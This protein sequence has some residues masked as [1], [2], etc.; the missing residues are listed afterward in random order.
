M[1]KDWLQRMPKVELHLH[2]EGSVTPVDLSELARR[3]RLPD[4]DWPVEAVEAKYRYDDF[5]GFLQAFKWITEHLIRPGDYGWIASRQIER[6]HTA[7]VI[8]AE[9]FFS[10]GV[11]LK[12]GKDLEAILRAV[13]TASRKQEQRWG[14]RVNWIFDVTRQ[15]GV[16]LA[17]QVLDA[18][19]RL[20]GEGWGNVVALGMGGDENS[21]SAQA[22]VPVFSRAREAGLHVTIHAGE[23]AGPQSIWEALG[24]LHAERIGHGVAARLDERLMGHLAERHILLECA[25]TSNLCTGVIPRIEDHPLRLF[26]DRNVPVC[27]N[28]DDPPLFHTDLVREYR[29]AEKHFQFTREDFIR[30]NR[31]ALEGS[32]LPQDQKVALKSRFEQEVNLFRTE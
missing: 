7:G 14:I 1:A 19:L 22:F 16:A 30:L 28:T 3:N 11:V 4:A 31:N 32:F 20:R 6:L 15:F 23:V 17:G 10:P 27:L 24:L 13:L 25:P 18:A 8:Y 5:L 26:Y 12:Q 29:E 2:L 9:M 21:I